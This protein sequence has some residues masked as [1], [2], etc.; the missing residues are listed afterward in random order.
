MRLG[1]EVTT[2]TALRTGVGY[3]TEHLVDALLETREP[4]DD[5]VLWSNRP[6]AAELAARWS[7]YL[8]VRGPRIRA[9]WMQST[10]PRLVSETGVDVAVFP[11]YAAPLACP[12]ASMVVVH[13]LAIL[14]TPEHFTSPKRL[15]MRPTLRLSVAAAS[16]I[17]TVSQASK[18]DITALLGVGDER[19]ALLPCAAHPSCAP[20]APRVVTEVRARYGLLRPYVLTVGTLEPR[21]DLL[22]ILRAFDRLQREG[23]QHD[24][25]VV[26]G[27]GW[28]DDKLVRALEER[29]VSKRVRWLGYVSEPDLVALYSGADLFV[30]ASTLEGFGLP[31]LEAMA[32]GT[33]VIAS[34]VPALREVGGE[35]ARFVAPGDDAAFAAEIARALRDDGGATTARTAGLSRARQ[36][37][38]TRTAHALWSR[39][40]LMGPARVARSST[41]Q[42]PPEGAPLPPP[43]HPPAPGLST[44][45]WALLAAVVYADLFH[46]P[47]PLSVVTR[48]SIGVALA[49]DEV[50]RMATSSPLSRLLTLHPNGVLVLSG[51][52]ELV[53]G[54]AEREALARRLLERNHVRLQA[55][56]LLPFIRALLISGGVAHRNPGSRPDV[57]LFVVAARGRAYTAYTMLFVAT[58]LTGNRRL[59]CP[60]YMVDENELAI[61]Y[62][63]DLFT[64][65][66][67]V[68]SVPFS[69]RDTYE[70][71]CRANETWIRRFF[72]GFAPRGLASSD[73]PTAL[74]PLQRAGELVLGPVAPLL[75][76]S[77]RWAWRIRLRRRA[78]AAVRS[79]VVL[80][81][82]ILKLHLSDYRRSVLERFAARLASLR[83][84]L[85]SDSE[86]LRAGVA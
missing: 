26:G 52:E 60:N 83:V 4:G 30:L 56:A 71:L 28:R 31:V 62:H 24:L 44:R 5:V 11:N 48:G 66:Q 77:L 22:T 69:G 68:S 20:A 19:V 49:E 2:C 37:S 58:K 29:A 45:E 74:R 51:R 86:P 34:D 33:P 9:L 41:T 73:L 42:R 82:G 64:A 79:D 14:R 61:A 85:G 84:Q 75:E 76:S 65:H 67:L 46:S 78:A 81:N 70:A 53:D 15:L 35:V 16:V 23:I 72:P 43:V 55:L 47:L 54:M 12:C 50:R 7:Q 8:H 21:K 40:R 38:W 59:I 3:Y 39:A 57:D 80:G 36:F 25:V 1:V 27:R 17:G 18:R 63:H 6:P 32:C 10:V 13:D